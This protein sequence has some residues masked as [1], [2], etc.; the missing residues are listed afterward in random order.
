MGGTRS[1]PSAAL[2]LSAWLGRWLG[3]WR[4]TH[5]ALGSRLVGAQGW[6]VVW[7]LGFSLLTSLQAR[8]GLIPWAGWGL[9]GLWVTSSPTN[10]PPGKI[11]KGPSAWC[12][13]HVSCPPITTHARGSLDKGRG[14]SMKEQHS[15]MGPQLLSVEQWSWALVV[16]GSVDWGPDLER[17]EAPRCQ[18]P[19]TQKCHQASSH[20]P[21]ASQCQGHRWA[22]CP[23]SALG[24]LDQSI[25][26]MAGPLHPAHAHHGRPPAPA[27]PPHGRLSPAPGLRPSRL[28]GR[29]I[30][31]QLLSL[32]LYLLPALLREP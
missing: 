28:G 29:D 6:G 4:G 24:G 3:S 8:T 5:S 9:G 2:L 23:Q 18:T 17:N 20:F 19:G 32:S 13:L 26:L 12:Y 27:H 22:V 15:S 10:Q 7:G 31:H 25:S 30:P 1:G 11:P 16:W 14:M 21:R